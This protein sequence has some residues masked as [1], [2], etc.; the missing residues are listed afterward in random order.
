MLLLCD[1]YLLAK[2]GPVKKP[3]VLYQVFYNTESTFQLTRLLPKTASKPHTHARFCANS[4]MADMEL[5]TRHRHVVLSSRATAAAAS[6]AAAA[7]A[8]AAEEDG[9]VEQTLLGGGGG[10]GGGDV[11]NG[12]GA[13]V[14][15]R[16]AEACDGE[17]SFRHAQ[18]HA[19]ARR[20]KI[21]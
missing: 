1:L 9:G 5:G 10:G 7:T 2:A 18:T 20:R 11:G 21:G 15:P 14:G 12:N 4:K 6:A 16:D 3:M 19:P 13:V 17:Q 8:T